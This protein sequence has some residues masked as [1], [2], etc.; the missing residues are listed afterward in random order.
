MPAR[1]KRSREEVIDLTADS[2]DVEQ[3]EPARK[4]ARFP[5]TVNSPQWQAHHTWTQ[6]DD[7]DGDDDGFDIIDLSQE[8][9]NN[10]VGF[11]EAG[12]ISSFHC[13]VCSWYFLTSFRR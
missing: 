6:E 10:G 8:V 5:M 4:N 1:T 13:F 7:D 9:D 3:G 11:A 12:R 2:S